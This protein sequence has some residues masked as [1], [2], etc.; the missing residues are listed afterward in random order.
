MNVG[1]GI[2]KK[3]T[4]VLNS[5]HI[6][7]FSLDTETLPQINEPTICFSALPLRSFLNDLVTVKVTQRIKRR[8][9]VGV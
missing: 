8:I 6:A 9:Y 1:C 5:V 3:V 2:C 4:Y 7:S